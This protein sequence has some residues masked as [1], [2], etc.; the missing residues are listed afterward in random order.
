MRAT[1]R[2]TGSST[3]RQSLDLPSIKSHKWSIHPCSAVTGQGLD[4]GMDWVV[5]QVAQRLYWSGL[6]HETSTL[7]ESTSVKPSSE[8]L[9][10][11]AA[12]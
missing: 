11:V 10:G 1:I 5:A 7:S 12:T 2:L 3:D 8:A 6:Q 9:H 4:E